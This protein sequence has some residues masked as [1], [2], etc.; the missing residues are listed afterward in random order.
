MKKYILFAMMAITL[1]FASPEQSQAQ[2][3]HLAGGLAVSNDILVE[4]LEVGQVFNRSTLSLIGQTSQVSQNV[5]RIWAV[6]IKYERLFYSSGNCS[7]SANGSTLVNLTGSYNY[8][9]FSPG[10]SVAYRI[11]NNLSL[12]TNLN[13]PITEGSILFKPI[14]LQAGLQLVLTL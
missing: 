10:L 1:A 5:N 11:N 12:N 13:S 14:S 4:N 6:G 3:T 9:T 8:L 2:K 7:F